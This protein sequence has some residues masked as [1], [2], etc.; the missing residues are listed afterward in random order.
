MIRTTLML[1]DELRRSAFDAARQRGISFGELVREAIRAAI[2]S[3]PR[4]DMVRDSFF[5]DK[6]VYQGPAPA[7][8]SLRHDDYLYGEEP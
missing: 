1:P 7:D 6:A 2:S 5:D 4:A 8:S 3:A